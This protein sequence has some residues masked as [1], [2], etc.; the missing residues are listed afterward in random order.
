M[1]G[2][3]FRVILPLLALLA[4]GLTAHAD[5]LRLTGNKRWLVLAARST[6]AE[7]VAVA[8]GFASTF[9]DLRVVEASNGWF[10]IVVGPR[11]GSSLN[12]VRRGLPKN[13]ALPRDVYVS[14]GAK[15]LNT[16]W[17]PAA[18]IASSGDF[19]SARTT[20]EGLSGS[21][22]REVQTLLSVAG[23]WPAVATPGFSRRLFEATRKFQS[24]NDRPVTGAL[25]PGDIE[26]LRK[27][28]SPLL[29]Q[30]DL[31]PVTQPATG[32]RLWVPA[33]LLGSPKT[34]EYG[35]T[36]SSPSSDISIA[37][38]Y[39]PNI[40]LESSYRASLNVAS[41]GHVYYKVLRSDFF[42]ISYD[43]GPA[44]FY[45]RFHRFGSGVTGFLLMW[46]PDAPFHGERIASVMSDFFRSSMAGE[47]GRTPPVPLLQASAPPSAA[48]TP[49]DKIAASA[50]SDEDKASGSGSGFGV[51]KGFLVT[52]AHVVKGCSSVR[53]MKGVTPYPAHVVA[54]DTTNDLALIASDAPVEIALLRTEVRL[55]EPVGVFGFPL[56]G[57]LASS[58]NYTT[59]IVTATAG[60]ADNTGQLQ[61]SAPVQPGN[62]GGPLVDASGN[63][64]GVIV[65]KLDAFFMVSI[66]KDLPENVNFAIKSSVLTNFLQ[67]NQVQPQTGTLGATSLSPDVAEKAVKISARVECLN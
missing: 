21:Q 34:I 39:F 2:R 29:T 37:Y 58:G 22:K 60:M 30:W 47:T 25:A 57:I 33:G 27:L 1:G 9:P 65:A 6:Q 26:E 24:E 44:S 51:A 8:Q 63:V 36:L 64:V 16:V 5:D 14:D 43:E 10:A 52:N 7:A 3:F 35:L 28:A 23:Y 62:S 66:T 17:T 67:A 18:G 12:E 48:M 11:R 59:G 55:G 15:Y 4:F 49:V 40:A 42:A 53:V 45:T 61:I 31:A 56:T 46:K 32:I 20:F 41:K 19:S 54:K 13:A 38:W 50:K